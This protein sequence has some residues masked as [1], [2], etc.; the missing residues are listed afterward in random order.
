EF[1]S[2]YIWEQFRLIRPNRA[3]F[4]QRAQSRW[5][6][7]VLDFLI[8][9]AP[10]GIALSPIYG[11]IRES[12]GRHG[13][14]PEFFQA[15]FFGEGVNLQVD[16]ETVYDPAR[17]I[18]AFGFAGLDLIV[19]RTGR[20]PVGRPPHPPEIPAGEL[21]EIAEYH[22]NLVTEGFADGATAA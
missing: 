11:H 19:Y 20:L 16:D 8:N 21:E 14:G 3:P 6:V 12:A 17:V 18:D 10:G 7:T 9:S 15:V 22:F 2:R 4:K 1:D 5:N 13:I